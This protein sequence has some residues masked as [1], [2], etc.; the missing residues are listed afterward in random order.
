MADAIGQYDEMRV[1][2]QQLS[3]IKELPSESVAEEPAACAASPMHDQN[4]ISYDTLCV[5]G[6]RSDRAIVLLQLRQCFTALEFEVLD[7]KVSFDRRG[8]RREGRDASDH[9][10]TQHHK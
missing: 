8:I 7:D 4:G 1:C 5:A 9:D 2:V 6:R 10:Q 3:G